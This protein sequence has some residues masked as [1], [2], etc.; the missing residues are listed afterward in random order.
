MFLGDY[1]G[2][3]CSGFNKVKSIVS[4][5]I[6]LFKND[7]VEDKP[8]DD[9]K[10][11]STSV[12]PGA[13]S[14]TGQVS[15]RTNDN[16][17][18]NHYNS[19][20]IINQ[21][22]QHFTDG[23]LTYYPLSEASNINQDLMSQ[24]SR[25]FVLQV[26]NSNN[27]LMYRN[28][29]PSSNYSAAPVMPPTPIIS[30]LITPSTMTPLFNDGI[31]SQHSLSSTYTNDTNHAVVGSIDPYLPYINSRLNGVRRNDD[32]QLFKNRNM[33]SSELHYRRNRIIENVNR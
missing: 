18:L 17:F 29:D 4:G 31:S 7:I 2:N 21:P 12:N 22:I 3:E 26:N 32:Y 19:D 23:R 24:N 16:G 13:I 15:S 8:Y 33:D 25:S 28:D 9:N 1:K 27:I 11:Y 6:T 10:T 5:R 20:Y 14:D 30:N